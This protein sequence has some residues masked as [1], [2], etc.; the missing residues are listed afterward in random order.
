MAGAVLVFVIAVLELRIARQPIQPYG[1]A[2]AAWIEHAVR[3]ELIEDLRADPPANPWGLLVRS[4]GESHPPLLHLAH[5]GLGAI[6]GH[7]PA[8]QARFAPLW[9]VLL[10]VSM[11]LVGR[12]LGDGRAAV[13]AF[14]G[15]LLLPALHGSATRVHYDL[16][17]TALLWGAVAVLVTGIRTRAWLVAPLA[18]L[19]LFAAAL[20]KWTAVPFGGLM[21]LGVL[22]TPVGSLRSRIGLVLAAGAVAAAG[23]GAYLD[24]T[25]ASFQGGQLA[26]GAAGIGALPW[27]GARL[28]VAVLSPLAA[29]ALARLAIS[30]WRA[31]RPG[32]G[33]VGITVIGQV[34]FLLAMVSVRDERFLL[35]LAPA[36]V[37]LGAL[38]WARTSDRRLDVALLA[39]LAGLAV[40]LHLGPG[41]LTGDSVEQRGWAAA[42][43]TANDHPERREAAWALLERWPTDRIALPGGIVDV[44]DIWWLRARA[45]QARL[46][47]APLPREVLVLN[48]VGLGG[49]DLWWPDPDS[50]PDAWEHERLGFS[51][52]LLPDPV[53]AT[54]SEVAAAGFPASIYEAFTPEVVLARLPA[55]PEMP[56]PPGFA[57]TARA[58]DVG[59]F[60]SE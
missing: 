43:R 42:A 52:D 50:S 3:L 58:A 45:A 11:A 25:T 38:G 34:A 47:G 22:A 28:V 60:A 23:I 59:L 51:W 29:L 35:T 13:G 32:A 31:G 7:D 2:A 27:Y 16:P 49:R 39:V 57:L 20:T 9:L 14:V 53:P 30:W 56:L 12:A 24:A 26:V 36:L 37:L 40:D 15:T 18:G 46:Q 54:S 41:M 44:G 21:L 10:A 19:L 8:I 4:D 5:A 1:D 55:D 17:M 33:L 6:T 48:H